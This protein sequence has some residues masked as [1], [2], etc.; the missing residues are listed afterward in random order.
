MSEVRS[1]RCGFYGPWDSEMK[2]HVS[3]ASN[4]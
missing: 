3:N 2:G 4:G 1:V